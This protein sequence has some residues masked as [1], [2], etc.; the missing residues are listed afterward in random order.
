MPPRSTTSGPRRFPSGPPSHPAPARSPRCAASSL[1][2]AG[3]SW[4]GRWAMAERKI[5][6]L[7]DRWDA[8]RRECAELEA[9]KSTRGLPHDDPKVLAHEAEV[10]ASI[11][12]RGALADDAWALPA[13]DMADLLLLAEIAY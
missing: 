12:R 8:L 4:P 2:C 5:T 3:A 11:V 13:R 10:A 9:N 7:R 1:S 6:D